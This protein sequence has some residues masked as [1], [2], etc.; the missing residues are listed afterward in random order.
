M[1]G[2]DSE[3]GKHEMWEGLQEAE[4]GKDGSLPQTLPQA[5]LGN[6]SQHTQYMYICI[7]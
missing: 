6:L 1:G 3:D 2:K 7:K 5:L 4:G